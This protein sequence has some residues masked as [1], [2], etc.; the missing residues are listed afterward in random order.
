MK[1]EE[2]RERRPKLDKHFT[3]TTLTDSR[4]KCKSSRLKW[5][6]LPH[7]CGFVVLKTNRV[8]L[9]RLLLS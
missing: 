2:A 5:S 7:W 3:Q 6:L 1:D 9:V 8:V 4:S